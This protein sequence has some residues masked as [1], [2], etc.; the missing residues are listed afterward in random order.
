MVEL[1]S[2]GVFKADIDSPAHLGPFEMESEYKSVTNAVVQMETVAAGDLVLGAGM[3]QET[4]KPPGGAGVS[5][6]VELESEKRSVTTGP[7]GD[8]PGGPLGEHPNEPPSEPLSESPGKLLSGAGTF[9]LVELETE[10]VY[11]ADTDSQTH[12]GQVEMESEKSR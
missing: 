5:E 11:K 10:E 12:L 4:S 9:A 1:G 8:P 2:E 7:P 6:S 3:A